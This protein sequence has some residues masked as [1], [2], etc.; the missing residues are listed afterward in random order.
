[1]H[2]CSLVGQQRPSERRVAHSLAHGDVAGVRTP[3]HARV[4]GE[5]MGT[6]KYRNVSKSQS[7]LITINPIISTRTRIMGRGHAVSDRSGQG[8]SIVRAKLIGRRGGCAYVIERIAVGHVPTDC[9]RRVQVFVHMASGAPLDHERRVS[10]AAQPLACR[11]DARRVRVGLV[12]QAEPD[13][14]VE[15]APDPAAPVPV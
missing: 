4:R 8:D 10:L 7:V 15:R 13:Q 14:Q 9:R 6:H 5:M 12:A 3:L 11:R 2:E 1:M